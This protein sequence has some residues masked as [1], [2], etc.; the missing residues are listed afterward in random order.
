MRMQIIEHNTCTSGLNA[1]VTPHLSSIGRAG[2]APNGGGCLRHR[3]SSARSIAK[4]DRAVLPSFPRLA[5]ASIN[6]FSTLADFPRPAHF[7]GWRER[8]STEERDSE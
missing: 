6:G 7:N 4:H 1:R 3:V 2:S 5:F 8:L